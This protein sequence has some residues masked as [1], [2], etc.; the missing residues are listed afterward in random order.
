LVLRVPWGG[1]VRGALYHSQSVEAFYSHVPGLKVVAP[2]TPADAAG[3]LRSAI[4]D[5]DPVLFL[6]HKKAYR[7]VKGEVPEGEYLVPIGPA[8][9]R[10]E[11][12]DLT[13]VSYGLSLHH[14]L[15]AAERLS[16]E[17]GAEAE[18]I[19]LRT[20]S[21]LDRRTLL[22]SVAKTGR[23][24]VV[25]EDNRSFGAGAEVVALV[26]EE[27]FFHLDAPPARVAG[28][29]IPA[30]PFSH[31]M[32]AFYLPDPEKIYRAMRALAEV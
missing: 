11:G 15:E 31:P 10:R 4:R 2:S 12:R 1:G 28:P 20:I 7:L 22:D 19:D 17:V 16:R 6:E 30:M 23:L 21:P 26:A 5:P 3:L 14:C 18:V 8:E 27:G 24:L 32:E 29:D 9:V 25:H 13:C